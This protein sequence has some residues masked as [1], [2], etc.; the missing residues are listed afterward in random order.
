MPTVRRKFEEVF[1]EG[2]VELLFCQCPEIAESS[3]GN[4]H[5][6]VVVEV[7]GCC[8][9]DASAVDAYFPSYSNPCLYKMEN[10]FYVAEYIFRIW[11][12]FGPTISSVIPDEYVYLFVQKV[13]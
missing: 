3:V 1:G 12:A 11:A 5:V 10:L 6:N 2:A 8:A 4:Q 7:A 13:L 9:A